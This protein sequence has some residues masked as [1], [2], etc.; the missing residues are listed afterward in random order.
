MFDLKSFSDDRLVDWMKEFVNKLKSHASALGISNSEV[1]S[2]DRDQ[3]SMS[4]LVTEGKRLDRTDV[5]PQIRREYANYKE[6]IKNGPSDELQTRFPSVF[7]STATKAAPGV[8]PRVQEFVKNLQQKSSLSPSMAERLGIVG[9]SADSLKNAMD[10]QPRFTDWLGN[11]VRGVKEHQSQ[12]GVNNSEL[13]SLEDDYQTS[14]H[15]VRGMETAR[16]QGASGGILNQLMGYK[17][18]IVNGPSDGLKRVV[19]GI[20]GMFVAPGII[21]RVMKFIDQLKG[22]PRFEELV[23]RP[24][25]ISEAAEPAAERARETVGTGT[26]S[27][28]STEARYGAGPSPRQERPR[29]GL[30]RWLLPLLALLFIGGLIIWGLLSRRAPEVARTPTAPRTTVPA[31][32]GAGPSERPRQPAAEPRQPATKPSQPAAVAAPLTIS[33]MRFEPNV[34]GGALAWTTNRPATGQIEY[35][36]TPSYELGRAPRTISMDAEHFVTNH[37]TGLQGLS[38][39]TRYYVRATAQDK[40]GKRATSQPYSFTAP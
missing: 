28:T 25:G 29:S 5:D 3:T 39:G 4:R 34:N 37:N 12:L 21:S 32:P 6:L 2:V 14:Q 9:P 38:P 23:G 1:D 40:A 19:P 8:I 13:K 26:R 7:T 33:N 10:N 35:G 20:L 17:D 36:R 22:K 16:G 31:A 15:L 30:G 18:M 11:L 24:M 27:R